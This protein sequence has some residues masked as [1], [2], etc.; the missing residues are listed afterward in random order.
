MSTT[1]LT[2]AQ[3]GTAGALQ[4]ASATRQNERGVIRALALAPQA[5]I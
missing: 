1:A 4:H 3:W 5:A 2:G